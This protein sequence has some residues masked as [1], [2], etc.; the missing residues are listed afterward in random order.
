[1]SRQT[2]VP[3]Y[4]KHAKSG[5]AVVTLTGPT[6]RRDI[7]VGAYGSLDSHRDYARVIAEW[8]GAVAGPTQIS[9][10]RATV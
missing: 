2:K 7:Y 9:N 3:T 8:T 6:G 10:R 4:R 5:Q 1:V